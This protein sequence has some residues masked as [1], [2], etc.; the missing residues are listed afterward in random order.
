MR[1]AVGLTSAHKGRLGARLTDNRRCSKADAVLTGGRY[2]V[3][4]SGWED[5]HEFEE[6]LITC[7]NFGG[8]GFDP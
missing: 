6:S 1:F 4:E 8:P 7:R 3:K 2:E 5:S